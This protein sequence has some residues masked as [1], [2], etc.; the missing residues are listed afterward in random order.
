MDGDAARVL[1]VEDEP[2]LR[3]A[4]CEALRDAALTVD[5]SPDGADFAA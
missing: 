5:T 1:V 3:G 4:I 2:V